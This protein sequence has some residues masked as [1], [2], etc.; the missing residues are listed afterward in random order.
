MKKYI[1]LLLLSLGFLFSVSAV[2]AYDLTLTSV[3]SVSTLGTNYSLVDYKGDIPKLTGTASPSAEVAIKIKTLLSH[4]TASISGVWQFTPTALDQ[5]DNLIVL[6][7][8]VQSVSFT[9]R[10]NATA[11]ATLSGTPAV[12]ADESELLETGIWDY[13]L[14]ILAIGVGVIFFGNYVKKRMHKWEKGG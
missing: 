13:Y 10:F 11:S 5:G 8:G 7:S 4:T 12:V 2:L 9:L 1:S 3:G 6:S 14:L